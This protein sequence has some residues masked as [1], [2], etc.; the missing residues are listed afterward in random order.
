[1]LLMEPPPA[2]AH[3]IHFASGL[4]SSSH[5]LTVYHFHFHTAIIRR[6][7]GRSLDTYE[8][9]DALFP[10][11]KE[12]PP[13]SPSFNF[14]L[15]TEHC[16]HTSSSGYLDGLSGQC[17]SVTVLWLLMLLLLHVT[18]LR[19]I[20]LIALAIVLPIILPIIVPYI[21]PIAGPSGRAV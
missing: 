15:S 8:Q 13:S 14:E 18:L 16:C 17:D 21:R 12:T 3:M 1:M 6:T 11:R 4:Y 9:I 10:A 7:S 2:L 20:Q 19:A 5:T